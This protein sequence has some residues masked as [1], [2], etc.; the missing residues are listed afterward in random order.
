MRPL[1]QQLAMMAPTTLAVVLVLMSAAPLSAGTLTYTP[2]IAW[3]MTLVLVPSHPTTWPRGFAFALG[4]LQDLVFGTPLGA[5]ALLS[6]L[7][8][9]YFA[10]FA[11]TR[12]PQPFRFRWAE[13]TG[14]LLM[15]HLL[16]ALLITMVAPE[17]V[18][19]SHLVRTGLINAFWYPLFCGVGTRL[20][21]ALPDAR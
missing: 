4:L 1:S 5:Q 7:L 11:A 10:R 15:L 14:I 8:A 18:N 19:L 12:A 21:A 6:L 2:N 3:L 13:A 16:L 17:S 9:H 20:F